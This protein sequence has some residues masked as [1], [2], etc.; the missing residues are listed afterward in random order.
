MIEISHWS[1]TILDID[2]N[3]NE[4]KERIDELEDRVGE[5]EL[6]ISI[7]ADGQLCINVSE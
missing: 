1:Q 6:P 2:E 3:I 5:I 7:N 4:N